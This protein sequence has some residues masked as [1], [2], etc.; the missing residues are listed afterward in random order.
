MTGNHFSQL[1]LEKGFGQLSKTHRSL[2]TSA[3]HARTHTHTLTYTHTHTCEH[4]H[5][6]TPSGCVKVGSHQKWCSFWLP[7]KPAPKWLLSKNTNPVGPV[8][9]GFENVLLPWPA[10]LSKMLSMSGCGSWTQ[11][12]RSPSKD[13]Q[14]CLPGELLGGMPKR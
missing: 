4:T 10:P 7:F 8:C 13:R 12:A 5:T 11:E 9:L 6:H 14:G 3:N 2:A 1:N